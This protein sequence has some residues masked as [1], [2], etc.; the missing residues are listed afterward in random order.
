[1]YGFVKK[2]LGIYLS[3]SLLLLPASAQKTAAD[4]GLVLRGRIDDPHRI[5]NKNYVIWKARLLMEFTN[6]GKETL[7]IANPSSF[8]AGKREV[9]FFAKEYMLITGKPQWVAL[10]HM[11]SFSDSEVSTL[12]RLSPEL[13]QDKPPENLVV[14]LKPGETLNFEDPISIKQEIAYQKEDNR[15]VAKIWEGSIDRACPIKLGSWPPEK[16]CPLSYSSVMEL[17]YEFDLSD[18]L[19][20]PALL[21]TLAIRWRKFGVLP[22]NVDDIVSIKSQP[23]SLD[24]IIWTCEGK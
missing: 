9:T 14:T 5:E 2:S 6:E 7:L 23:I 12:K 3:V 21:G 13:D 19:K 15:V 20:D 8:G 17:K 18:Y 22:V 1:M 16:G 11:I 24:S 10:R 4:Y